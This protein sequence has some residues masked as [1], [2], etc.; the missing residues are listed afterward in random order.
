MHVLSIAIGSA[1]WSLHFKT[2]EAA[3]SAQKKINPGVNA[4]GA[5]VEITD[6]FG[7]LF[8]GAHQ[9]VHGMM[10]EDFDVANNIRGERWISEQREQAKAMSKAANDPQLKAIHTLN[11]GGMA[12][13]ILRGN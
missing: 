12:G 1:Q 8:R 3:Q 13:G 9:H 6:D 11:G 4:P 7:Q 10:V 5:A 2:A